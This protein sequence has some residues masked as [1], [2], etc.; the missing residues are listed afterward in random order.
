MTDE[1]DIDLTAVPRPNAIPALRPEQPLSKAK[2]I[3]GRSSRRVWGIRT[4]PGLVGEKGLVEWSKDLEKDGQKTPHSPGDKGDEAE[5][6]N[7]LG[8]AVRLERQGQENEDGRVLTE[9]TEDETRR[10]GEKRNFE[11]F[12]HQL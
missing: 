8:V 7:D 9:L 10:L 11:E 3:K 2:G 1:V 4:M 12:L 6:A 5:I